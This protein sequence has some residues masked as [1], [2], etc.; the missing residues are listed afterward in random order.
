MSDTQG[1]HPV[2]SRLLATANAATPGPWVFATDK[3]A[4][5]YVQL[6]STAEIDEYEADVLSGQDGADVLVSALNAA[7]IAACDPTTVLRLLAV[8]EAARRSCEPPCHH[9]LI[10]AALEVLN[11]S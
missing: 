11:E 2:L 6:Y 1:Q 9:C 10:C 7:F 8:V 3:G 4:P 5:E